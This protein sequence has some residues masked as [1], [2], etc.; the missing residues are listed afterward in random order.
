MKVSMVAASVLS[1]IIV[2]PVMAESPF[3]KFTENVNKADNPNVEE[4]VW[5]E[6]VTEL[7]DYPQKENLLEF[8]VDAPGARFRYFID[9]KSLQVGE[10]DGVVRYALIIRSKSGAEN[11]TFEGMR[12][13]TKEYKSYAFGNGK[14]EWRKPRKTRWMVFNGAGY[15]KYR[16]ALWEYYLCDRVKDQPRDVEEIATAIRYPS[17]NNSKAFLSD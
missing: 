3:R 6:G 4:Y 12:C 11:V 8:D 17:Q 5:Q 7:P 9:E 10:G 13:N 16:F 14:G 1:L 15:N 2:F